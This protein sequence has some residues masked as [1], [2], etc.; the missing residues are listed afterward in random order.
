MTAASKRWRRR[1]VKDELS[2]KGLERSGGKAGTKGHQGKVF[3]IALNANGSVYERIIE[4]TGSV[5][6]IV[7]EIG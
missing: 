4:V 7:L 3:A 6:E 2:V 5:P 1:Y